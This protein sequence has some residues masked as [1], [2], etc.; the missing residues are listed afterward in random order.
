MSL[1][2]VETVALILLPAT[3]PTARTTVSGLGS[4]WTSEDGTAVPRQTTARM[5]EWV[6]K[7]LFGVS[8]TFVG[9]CVFL[10]PPSSLNTEGN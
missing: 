1:V 6:G 10:A 2:D 7:S 5:S 3:L 8:M 4:A 9:R